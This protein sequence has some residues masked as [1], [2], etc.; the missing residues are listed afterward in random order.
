MELQKMDAKKR[1]ES[2]NKIADEVTDSPKKEIKIITP[3]QFKKY[4]NEVP[5]QMQLVGVPASYLGLNIDEIQRVHIFLNGTT[6]V[7]KSLDSNAYNST[8]SST[9]I[10]F[11]V[12]AK[13]MVE[14][15]NFL[16]VALI[17]KGGAVQQQNVSFMYTFRKMPNI[18]NNI[19]IVPKQI[20]IQK[21][22]EAKKN[23]ADQNLLTFK[24]I[25]K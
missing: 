18:T 11:N 24:N 12:L 16:T 20:V 3:V 4:S 9:Q 17:D 10:K 22:V 8:T 14:G 7:L 15:V 19:T 23:I 21:M 25:R 2:I 13:D 6:I 1:Q 5:V